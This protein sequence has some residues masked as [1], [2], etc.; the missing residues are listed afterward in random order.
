M[1][2]IGCAGVGRAVAAAVLML[3]LSLPLA[4][5]ALDAEAVLPPGSELGDGARDIPREVFRSEARGGAKSYLVNLGNLAFNA[6]MILGG[7]ARKAGISCG[8]CHVSGASNA[9]FYIPGMSTRPGTFDTTGPLFNP[10]ADNGV[11][12]AVVIPSLRG[13]RSLAPYGHDGRTGSLRDFIRTVIVAE[14]AGPEPSPAIVDAI[15]AY[16]EDI[17]FLPNPKLDARG[18]LTALASAPE[19]RGEALFAKPFPHDPALSCA[20]C[21]VPSSAFVD[22]LQHDVGSGGL[23]KTPTLRNADF[24]A[25]YFHDG[26]FADYRQV[27]AHFDRVFDLALAPSE[28]QDLVAYL[29]AVGDG[30]RPYE[31]DGAVARL[32]ELDEFASVLATAIPTRD[33]P[34]I[35]LTVES[36]GEG[37]RQLTEAFPDPGNTTP[38]S[39]EDQRRLARAALDKLK[40]ILRRIGDDAAAGQ[41]DAAAA[42]YDNYRKLTVAAVPAALHAAEPWSAFNAAN[43]TRAGVRERAERAIDVDIVDSRGADTPT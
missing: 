23:F 15:L 42:E 37:L 29:S 10:R 32:T 40:Q 1:K 5:A 17:D 41:F 35:A 31:R 36:V 21:H 38:S 14:F 20:G 4:S 39:G 24:N 25:P 11:L 2:D 22:H 34:V 12:D 30:V 6:P 13:A 3:Q 9:R 26:R 7:A 19:R 33:E 27:V 28:Q 8:T 16:I 43:S 18:R